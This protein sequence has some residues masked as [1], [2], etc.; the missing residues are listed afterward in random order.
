LVWSKA[1]LK[2]AKREEPAFGLRVTQRRRKKGTG[3]R[4]ADLRKR[5]VCVYLCGFENKYATPNP[6][7]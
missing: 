3:E 2:A 7:R 5:S 4:F 6:G 1:V